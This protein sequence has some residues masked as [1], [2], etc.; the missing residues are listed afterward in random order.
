[1]QHY[2]DAEFARLK[3]QHFANPG[4]AEFEQ[5]YNSYIDKRNKIEDRK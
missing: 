1:M 2:D 3:I 5:E 4:N